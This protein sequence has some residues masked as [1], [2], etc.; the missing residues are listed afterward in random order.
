L[1]YLFV[2]IGSILLLGL[3]I[4][5]IAPAPTR[6]LLTF[7]VGAPE[8]SPWLIVG[9]LIFL[10]AGLLTVRQSGLGWLTVTVSCLALILSAYPLAS[11]TRRIRRRT[12]PWFK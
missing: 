10:S 2:A 6:W 4:W 3:S 12:R 1:R 5:A 8:I 9:N 11:F 7:A